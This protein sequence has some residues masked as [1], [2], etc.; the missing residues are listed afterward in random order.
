M[1][2]E[3]LVSIEK[4]SDGA[5]IAYNKEGDSTSIGTGATVSEAIDD[6]RRTLRELADVSSELGIDVPDVCT[7]QPAFKFDVSSL[8]DY[9]DVI[10]MA[11]FAKRI[12]MNSTLLRQ[13]KKGGVYISDNQLRRI[14]QG[15][16]QLGE[17]LASVHLF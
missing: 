9:Y 3:Y 15:V 13:Y 17:E 1:D 7:G 8:F 16:R 11:A 14:E 10:N 2:K 12:G 4:Q 5:F 6:Y